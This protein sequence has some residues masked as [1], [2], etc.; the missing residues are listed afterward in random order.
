MK[1]LPTLPM[2]GL[3]RQLHRGHL[4]LVLGLVPLLA[5]RFDWP[6][7]S[8]ELQ[9]AF[10]ALGAAFLWWA[11]HGLFL[12]TSAHRLRWFMPAFLAGLL[13]AVLIVDVIVSWAQPELVRLTTPAQPQ[14]S[15]QE[16]MDQMRRAMEERR[17]PVFQPEVEIPF[18]G[19][20]MIG[21]FGAGLATEFAKALCG[22]LRRP[23][24]SRSGLALFFLAGAGLG[25]GAGL[26][27]AETTK[28]LDVGASLF[29]FVT[30]PLFHAVLAAMSALL[31]SRRTL[32][33]GWLERV[34]GVVACLLPAAV[35]HG[36]FLAFQ[37]RGHEVLG[38]VT[39]AA[40]VGFF[41]WLDRAK[42]VPVRRNG[43]GQAL[44]DERHKPRISPVP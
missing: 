25:L 33:T 24:D 14:P 34:A 44:V 11:A 13:P 31:L 15:F 35:F 43:S 29:R 17:F 19:W 2:Q 1:R 22:S 20:L 7:G 36:A 37:G 8:R 39:V 40:A 5:E 16:F 27:E 10:A 4:A 21:T 41:V 32:A 26:R 30:W 12:R 6:S 23:T 38:S 28:Y 18:L 42:P 9:Y 3:Y